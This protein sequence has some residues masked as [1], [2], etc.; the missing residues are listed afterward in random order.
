MNKW[1][2]AFA[3][4]L[5]LGGCATPSNMID[6]ADERKPIDPQK[7]II[8][9]FVSEGFLTQPHGLYVLLKYQD[10]NP[11]AIATRIALTTLDQNNEVLGKP[12]IMG[13]TF[14]YEVPAGTYDVTHW[15]YRF[16]DGFSAD[17]KKPLTFSV[18][19]GDVAY[20]G[21][22]HANSLTMCLSNTDDFAKAVIDIKKAHPFLANV[23]ITNLSHD[24]QF[25]GWPNTKATDVFGKGL[26]KVQ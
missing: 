15:F 14:V 3:A 24:L 11:Q 16:Y 13:N 8:V 12:H 18:K 10:P 25:P 19:P 6:R 1:L 17:Q 23:A 21:N 2:L 7:A 5:S 26:C 20:I 4:M 9:G 22:F